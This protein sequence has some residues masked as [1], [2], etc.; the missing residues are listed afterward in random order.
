MLEALG[1]QVLRDGVHYADAASPEI[2]R[3]IAEA[4]PRL[5][6]FADWHEDHGAVLWWRFPIEEPPYIGGPTDIGR[7]MLV[8]VA[9]GREHFEMPS[10]NTGGW[11][12]DEEDEA[13]LFWQPIAIPERPA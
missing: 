8:E 3:E 2:A 4:T 10:Q 7:T 1:K 11:P 9:I 6:S 5:R 13:N 12:F